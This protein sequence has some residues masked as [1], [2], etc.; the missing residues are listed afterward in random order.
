MLKCLDPYPWQI[1]E[2]RTGWGFGQIFGHLKCSVLSLL[3]R[4]AAK[5]FTSSVKTLYWNQVC[6]LSLL[7][8]HRFGN[9]PQEKYLLQLSSLECL[10]TMFIICL[11]PDS[12]KVF[13][14]LKTDDIFKIIFQGRISDTRRYLFITRVYFET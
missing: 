2:A 10:I 4:E 1:F 12:H 7:H 13:Y 14:C 8:K 5:F 9:T 11:G 3:F 6:L